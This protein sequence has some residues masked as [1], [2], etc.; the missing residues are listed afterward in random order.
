MFWYRN[1]GWQ[2]E[3]EVARVRELLSAAPTQQAPQADIGGEAE[4]L[5]E[6]KASLQQV[7]AQLQLAEQVG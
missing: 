6:A 1:V 4:E 3:G 5:L 2:A 7:R